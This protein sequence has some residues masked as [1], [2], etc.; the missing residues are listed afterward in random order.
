MK[1]VFRQSAIHYITNLTV[2]DTLHFMLE[3]DCEKMKLHE[4]GKVKM[5]KAGSLAAV[6]HTKL[7]SDLCPTNVYAT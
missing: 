6:K 4:T 2:L 5:R 7:Y 3:E 1:V